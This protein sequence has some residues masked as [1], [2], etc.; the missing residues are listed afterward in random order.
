[1]KKYPGGLIMLVGL[2]AASMVCADR[3][4]EHWRLLENMGEGLRLWLLL[5]IV[6]LLLL[7][8]ML[9]SCTPY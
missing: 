7:I 8:V 5:M 3:A 1:M 4:L 6:W 9:T 2:S